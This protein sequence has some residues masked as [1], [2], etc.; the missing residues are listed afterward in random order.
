MKYKAL[1]HKTMSSDGGSNIA[2]Y[3][4]PITTIT[5][6]HTHTYIH[7]NFHNKMSILYHRHKYIHTCTHVHELNHSYTHINY[8]KANIKNNVPNLV[9]S[10]LNQ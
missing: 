8:K 2:I 10:L 3:T 1:N 6:T 9:V 7:T 5:H 4:E